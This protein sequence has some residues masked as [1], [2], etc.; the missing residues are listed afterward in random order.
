MNFFIK[1]NVRN[2]KIDNARKGEH[3]HSLN[4]CK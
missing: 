4:D 1:I 2:D 3:Y